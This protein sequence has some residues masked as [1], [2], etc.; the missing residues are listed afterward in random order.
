MHLMNLMKMM[1]K[2]LFLPKKCKKNIKK[3]NNKTFKNN[4]LNLEHMLQSFI[5]GQITFAPTYK[6]EK[7]K[8]QYTN[9]RI[10]AWCD[11]ILWIQP[12]HPCINIKQI[13]YKSSINTPPISDHRPVFSQFNITYNKS[14]NPKQNSEWSV[15]ITNFYLYLYPHS[16][17]ANPYLT[18]HSPVLQTCMRTQMGQTVTSQTSE[19]N[20]S[21]DTTIN[22]SSLSCY[23]FKTK[24]FII[25]CINNSNLG[26][27]CLWIVVRDDNLLGDVDVIGASVIPLIDTKNIDIY[28]HFKRDVTFATAKKGY[29]EGQ[30]K[31]TCIDIQ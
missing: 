13:Y 28:V 5:E 21:S 15:T 9:K 18:I 16:K 6:F 24:Q 11:R 2:Q 1:K 10:S 25:K 12:P 23:K 22:S 3:K 8:N 7:G 20:C 26:N 17:I 29:I 14:W 30:M 4:I 27:G 19:S 31:C